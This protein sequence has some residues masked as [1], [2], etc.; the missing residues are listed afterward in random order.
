MRESRSIDLH[1]YTVAE[2]IRKF[3]HFYDACVRSGY[4]G[5]IEVIH[6]YG[7]SGVGGSIRQEL[8]KYLEAHAETFGEYLA[9][10]SL[11][12]PGVTIVYAKEPPAPPRVR[13]AMPLPNAAQ[14]AIRRFCATPKTKEQILVRL[15]GRFGDSVLSA[16][17]GKMARDGAL[18]A[19][20][21]GDGA[22]QYRAT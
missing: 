17:I 8:R 18:Q 2:A 21:T 20:R 10:E 12:N 22:V 3:A 4:R 6:G 13:R 1:A 7:S 16:E 15:R 14:D 5:R 9:G 11:R 19:I